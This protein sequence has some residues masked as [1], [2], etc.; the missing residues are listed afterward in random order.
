MW[1]LEKII[2]ESYSGYK[3]HESPQVFTFREQ[4][5]IIEEVID[6]WYEGYMKSDT[7]I[8]NYFKVRADDGKN[9]L[10]R[11]DSYNDEWAIVIRTR[12]KQGSY[13]DG[14]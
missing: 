11:Y 8:I 12:P 4:R 14:Y 6:Q 10:I 1:Y 13:N 9:Y 7:P 3:I 5:Y 2:V